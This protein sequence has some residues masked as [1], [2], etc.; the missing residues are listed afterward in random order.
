MRGLRDDALWFMVWFL[1]PFR[2]GC[3]RLK[4]KVPHMLGQHLSTELHSS[5][6]SCGLNGPKWLRR[7]YKLEELG[8]QT[9][10]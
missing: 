8:Q 3:K 6:R 7:G 4:I 9:T 5:L 10:G 2:S 1:I